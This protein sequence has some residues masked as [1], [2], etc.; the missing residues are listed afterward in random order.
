MSFLSLPPASKK[1]SYDMSIVQDNVDAA[2]KRKDETVSMHADDV[3]L[4]PVTNT[5]VIKAPI[6]S[7]FGKWSVI[8]RSF[9]Q[10]YNYRY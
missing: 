7:N 6:Q 8:L 9:D 3:V 5:E 10:M 4:L 1:R 2:K